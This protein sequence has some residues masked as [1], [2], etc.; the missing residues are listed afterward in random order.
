M[1]TGPGKRVATPAGER[2]MPDPM[3]DPMR[4]AVALQ[5]PSRRWSVPRRG[6]STFAMVRVG[7]DRGYL[8]AVRIP[9]LAAEWVF[10]VAAVACALAQIGIVLSM[11][12]RRASN[13]ASGA[14]ASGDVESPALAHP[15]RV[16]RATEIV[17]A[18]LP[19][20]ALGLLLVVTW[21]A[22]QHPRPV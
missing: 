6:S 8:S 5:N 14:D 3:V 18:L 17:W 16:R 21:Q 4:T 2:K 20:I 19:A 15:A 9:V 11:F 13:R 12:Q 7:I 10:L 1:A 22:M